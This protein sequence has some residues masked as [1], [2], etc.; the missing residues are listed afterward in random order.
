MDIKVK[1]SNERHMIRLIGLFSAILILSCEQQNNEEKSISSKEIE[2]EIKQL[3]LVDWVKAS[4]EKNKVWF[5]QHLAD[6]LIMTTGRTGQVT[7]KSQ[8]IDEITDPD[9]GSTGG[10]E[11]KIEDF[12]VIGKNDVAIATFK[13]LT[14]GK[15]KTGTYYREARYTEVWTR[16]EG[17]WQL[18]ASHSSLLPDS[19]ESSTIALYD[20]LNPMN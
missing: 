3:E 8:V 16:R 19:V 18:I 5:E 2:N 20:K 12:K 14:H 7:N 15:D 13:L 17:R 6:E 11:D 9:Y 4:E 1:Y 10:A